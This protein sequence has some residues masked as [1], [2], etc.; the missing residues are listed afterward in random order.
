MLRPW[1]SRREG[2]RSGEEG[3]VGSKDRDP[4]RCD[5]AGNRGEQVGR[6]DCAA[7]SC[8]GRRE[9]GRQGRTGDE[10]RQRQRQGFDGRDRS[11]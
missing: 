7:G 9:D 1:W 6:E 5:P 11:M 2:D 8:S 10:D 4:T 3:G